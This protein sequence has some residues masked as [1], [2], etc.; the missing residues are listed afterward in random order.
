MQ[1]TNKQTANKQGTDWTLILVSLQLEAQQQREEANLRLGEERNSTLIAQKRKDTLESL[2]SDLESETGR[3]STNHELQQQ[4][5]ELDKQTLAQLTS[6]DG[7]RTRNQTAASR[8][9]AAQQTAVL[10]ERQLRLAESDLV[11]SELVRDSAVEAVTSDK[12]RMAAIIDNRT[13]L[14]KQ[15]YRDMRAVRQF[16]Q[17]VNATDTQIQQNA[18]ASIH[19]RVSLLEEKRLAEVRHKALIVAEEEEEAAAKA[20]EGSVSRVP[21]FQSRGDSLKATAVR[22]RKRSL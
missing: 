19:V 15:Y 17:A 4:D 6:M 5:D 22:L 12:Q 3:L 18:K 16:A 8:A 1:T 7:N 11:E 21:R 2:M 9:E 20:A 14:S 13:G 10:R